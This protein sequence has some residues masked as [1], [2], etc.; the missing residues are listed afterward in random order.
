MGGWFID[1]LRDR[2]DGVVVGGWL[3]ALSFSFKLFLL[4]WKEGG[5]IP[6]IIG[7]GERFDF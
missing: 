2:A 5:R 1:Y 6:F 7:G 4:S 3:S